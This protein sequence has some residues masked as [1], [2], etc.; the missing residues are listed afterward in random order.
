MTRRVGR[1]IEFAG[2]YC[3]PSSA[4]PKADTPVSLLFE[5][6]NDTS[7]LGFEK[8]FRVLPGTGAGDRLGL[9]IFVGP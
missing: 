1:L 4:S 9:S 7:P 5:G 2:M 3:A 8:F 6:C